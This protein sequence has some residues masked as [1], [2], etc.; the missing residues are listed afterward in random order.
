MTPELL[1]TLLKW[2]ASDDPVLVAHAGWRLA[3]PDRLTP[4]PRAPEAQP[5]AHAPTGCCNG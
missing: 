1:T 4:D 5:I 3:R 2:L